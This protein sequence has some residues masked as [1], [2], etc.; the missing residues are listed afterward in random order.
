MDT[1]KIVN[2]FLEFYAKLQSNCTKLAKSEKANTI[3]AKFKIR[4]DFQKNQY[5]TATNVGNDMT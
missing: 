2:F 3:N 5:L 4:L 1:N